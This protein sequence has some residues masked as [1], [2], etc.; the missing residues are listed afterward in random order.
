MGGNL[1]LL[2]SD[3][4]GFGTTFSTGE[5]CGDFSVDTG[6]AVG[7]F[8]G[9]GLVLGGFWSVGFFEESSM[10][11]PPS[12]Q[13]VLK[14]IIKTEWTSKIYYKYFKIKNINKNKTFIIV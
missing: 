4:T 2:E 5:T 7:G 3:R 1:K 6:S 13:Y 11:T 9:A 14:G 12:G 10:G 8:W